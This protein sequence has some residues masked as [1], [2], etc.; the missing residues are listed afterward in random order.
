[1]TPDGVIA[2]D[3][4]G[5]YW[6]YDFISALFI[7]YQPVVKD[8]ISNLPPVA[9]RCTEEVRPR[10]FAREVVIGR[11]QFVAGDVIALGRVVVHGWVQ[12]AVTS[13]NDR[14]IVARTGQVDG[15]IRA[16][17]IEIRPGGIVSGEQTILT[18]VQAPL[19]LVEG[20]IGWLLL[21]FGLL[22]LVSSFLVTALMPRQLDTVSR[23]VEQHRWRTFVWGV[24]TLLV[25]FPVVLAV[26]VVSLIG[27]VVAPLVP[28]VCFLG[29]AMGMTVWGRQFGDS[30][31]KRL[32]VR[33]VSPILSSMLGIAVWLSLWGSGF[34]MIRHG[35][36]VTQATVTVVLAVLAL[37]TA[38]PLLTGLGAALLT[39]FGFR[40]YVLLAAE[41][42]GGTRAPQPTPPPVPEAPPTIPRSG[43]VPTV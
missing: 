32:R 43:Y 26:A 29:I 10:P 15:D 3:T 21:T 12:G 18:P 23:C 4:F 30:L 39:R 42:S 28:L 13:V 31:L 40:S 1:M 27:L 20:N 11:H 34:W 2:V 35:G 16:P 14:V 5:H 17:E 36:P 6:Q 25:F 37:L 24:L 8:E 38:F 9:D 41:L 7:P 22:L 19:S 33:T